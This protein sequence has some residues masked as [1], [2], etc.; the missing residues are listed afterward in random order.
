[1]WQLSAN[2]SSERGKRNVFFLFF[3]F[4]SLLPNP[5]FHFKDFLSELAVLCECEVT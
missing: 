2:Y 3:F 4:F 5:I 1:M